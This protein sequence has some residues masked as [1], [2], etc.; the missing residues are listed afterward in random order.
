MEQS[1]ITKMDKF[2]HLPP[3]LRHYIWDFALRQEAHDNIFIL[4]PL[5]SSNRGPRI[6]PLKYQASPLLSV[7]YESRKRA[8]AFYSV[9]LDVFKTPGAPGGL[10]GTSDLT[11]RWWFHDLGQVDDPRGTLYISP[12]WNTLALF[13]DNEPLF[14]HIRT[15]F[16]E[17]PVIMKG[18]K[19]EPFKFVTQNIPFSVTEKISNVACV[20]YRRRETKVE[21]LPL[22]EGKNK[23]YL[24]PIIP[25]AIE[26]VDV[27][28]QWKIRMFSNIKN[29]RC[30]SLDEAGTENFVDELTEHGG[31]SSYR[32]RDLVVNVDD[33]TPGSW[34]LI[35][36]DQLQRRNGNRSRPELRLKPYDKSKGLWQ[37]RGQV[38]GYDSEDIEE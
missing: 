5:E 4:C 11:K 30:L 22:L 34:N 17:C 10:A 2:P 20:L 15:K 8:L 9:K 6:L 1:L 36:P 25:Y 32:F 26:P 18:W 31:R 12:Q 7:N 21:R 29:Y 23:E 24:S 33:S 13:E 38:E 16:S 28:I 27:G 19:L 37:T 14:A 35:D 3:E